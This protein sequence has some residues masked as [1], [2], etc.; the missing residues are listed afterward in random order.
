MATVRRKS[1]SFGTNKSSK[2]SFYLFFSQANWYP[3]LFSINLGER[4]IWDSSGEPGIIHSVMLADEHYNPYVNES[5][6][7]TYPMT[8]RSNYFAWTFPE[9]GIYPFACGFHQEMVGA[10][11]VCDTDGTCPTTTTPTPTPTPTPC[12]P[13]P[14][15]PCPQPSPS[16]IARCANT[17]EN[18]INLV[19]KGIMD[20]TTASSALARRKL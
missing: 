18:Q 17:P 7:E 1:S 4:V 2:S 19:F 5:I 8:L 16:P 12:S 6:F 20:G 10:V 13:S 11:T 15:P 14:C 3:Y 9:P